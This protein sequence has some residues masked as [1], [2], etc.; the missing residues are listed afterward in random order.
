MNF[1]AIVVLTT[2]AAYCYIP[3]NADSDYSSI[4]RIIPMPMERQPYENIDRPVYDPGA[5]KWTTDFNNRLMSLF[6][7]VN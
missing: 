2:N 4:P 1:V 5:G 6:Y 3:R 7:A